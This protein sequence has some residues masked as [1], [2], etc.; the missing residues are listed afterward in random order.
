MR[1]RPGRGGS[2]AGGHSSRGWRGGGVG[3]HGRRG[4]RGNPLLDVGV[5][6][7]RGA[8]GNPLLL[9]LPPPLRFPPLHPRREEVVVVGPSGGGGRGEGEAREEPTAH[10]AVVGRLAVLGRTRVI[11]RLLLRRPPLL[12]HRQG[13][14]RWWGGGGFFVIGG[15]G[16]RGRRRRNGGGGVTASTGG[17][18]ID[19]AVFGGHGRVHQ[20][21][22]I[23]EEAKKIH[24][25]GGAPLLFCPVPP[26]FE[27][28]QKKQETPK[29]AATSTASRRSTMAMAERERV[30][31]SGLEAP[32]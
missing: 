24:R 11:V 1:R 26:F 12:L 2:D 18:G 10:R 8:G 25:K 6:G 29:L 32:R 9:L 21:C 5:H 28:T 30:W 27:E 17:I 7:R 20:Q 14:E 22:V 23:N 31:V 4:A 16:E 19:F 3:V 15:D 13:M